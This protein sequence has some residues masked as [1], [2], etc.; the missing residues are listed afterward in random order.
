M[1]LSSALRPGAASCPVASHKHGLLSL[2]VSLWGYRVAQGFVFAI[3]EINRSVHLLPNLTLGFSIRNSG[4]SVH[5]ALLET[6]SFLTGQEEPIPN[7]ACGLSLPWVAVVGDT[8]SVLTLSMAR[9]LGLSRFPQGVH[10]LQFKSEGLSLSPGSHL[11]SPTAL[12]VSYSSTLP[13]LSDKTQFPSFLRTLA[14]DLTSSYA[15]TQLDDDFGQQASSLAAPEP[16]QAGVCIE[17]QLYVPSQQSLEKIATIGLLGLRVSGQVWISKGTLHLAMALNVPGVSQV[18][19]G[20][21]GL[22]FHSSRVPGFPEFL[23][24]LHPSWTPEDM[25]IQRF[26][27]DTFGC[28]WPHKN[29]TVARVVRL[30]SGN[31][32]LR[33]QEYSFW[34]VSK[35][36]TAYTAVYSIAHAL[37]DLVACEPWDGTCADS[38]HFLP[39]QVRGRGGGW[40]AHSAKLQRPSRI[41]AAQLN[42]CGLH[43]SRSTGQGARVPAVT[44]LQ[45]LDS[46]LPL[47]H[48]AR[49]KSTVA[50]ETFSILASTSGLLGGVFIP[51]CYF[52]LLRPEQNTLAWLRQGHGAQRE[53]QGQVPWRRC[54]RRPAPRSL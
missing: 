7:Y 37:Q 51:K 30:C 28:T 3:E 34:K 32:S 9:L 42:A 2:S 13:I 1:S 20:S 29:G 53:R 26:W 39:W 25:F 4:D 18:L 54:S 33:S 38:G 22:M 27:E 15:V 52:I 31:E 12:Q 10:L 35:A 11:H 14:S 50:V 36:D 41:H 6:L 44:L 8:R 47:Y 24:H 5:G 43:P 19:Q 23:A 16:S 45:G 46:L 40:G 48:S 21:F 49:G 17:V